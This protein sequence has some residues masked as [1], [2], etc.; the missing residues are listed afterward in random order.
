M[1]GMM[2]LP[3]H[4]HGVQA[5]YNIFLVASLCNA[6]S[7]KGNSVIDVELRTSSA[8]YVK[9]FHVCTGPQPRPMLYGN[10]LLFWP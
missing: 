7:R 5:T 9:V 2:M 4:A 8:L 10:I 3:A 1:S 6:G